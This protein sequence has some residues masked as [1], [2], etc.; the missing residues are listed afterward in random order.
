MIRNIKF[1]YNQS[2]STGSKDSKNILIKGDNKD[3][4]PELL[5]MYGGKIKC[6][7]IDP[8]YN[9]G[10]NYHYYN[11]NISHELWLREMKRTIMF[12]KQFL[13]R[14]GSLWISI[15][16]KEM[17]YLKVECDRIFGRE[18]FAGTIVWQHRKSREN[19]AVF[20]CNHEYILVY[21]CNVKA[22]KKSRNLI[23]VDEEFI[24][25]KY[26][27]PDNDP[28][29]PWQSITASAQAGHGV[30][31]QYYTVVSPTGVE[32]QPPLGRC[33]V[34]NEERMKREIANGN[35][36]FG[37][38]GNN[39]PRIKKFL[40][41]ANIGLTPET[42]WVNGDIG[43]TD[44][45]KKHLLTLFPNIKNVFDTPKPEGLIKQILEIATDT[46][47]YVLDCFL[48]SGTTIAVAH[49]LH[50]NYI[51]IEIG[52]QMTDMVVKRLEN[53]IQGEQGGI[54]NCVGWKGGGDF[55]YYDFD[56][57]KKET[58]MNEEAS[59][60]TNG[61]ETKIAVCHQL[62][63]LD[64]FDKYAYAPIVE[65]DVLKED[66]AAYATN[67]C[68]SD[69][70]EKK[71]LICLVKQDNLEQYINQ[72]AKL[73]YTGRKFPATVSLNE[74]YYFVPYLKGKGIRDLYLIKVVRVGN[75]KEGQIGENKNDF[76]LVFEIEFIRQLYEDYKPVELKIWRAFT[77]TTLRDV[78][79]VV[80]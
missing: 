62:N 66:L 26:K 4:L 52:E 22:F 36:W 75:R 24:N 21:A 74:L 55:A 49:K 60:S 45:A 44:S 78:M 33:W 59:I 12:L 80:V 2:L 51:G 39:A 35:I 5:P 20:S 1:I 13:R 40:A 37:I 56:K 18:N 72:S 46:D 61:Q 14:D 48:G 29:G 17:A 3:V 47:D 6:I 50:R 23:P 42:L 34:Y 68:V 7:Y 65:N 15:D 57:N 10:D 71:C 69:S 53:V 67:E 76:R 27:N 63:F 58:I 9:N 31:S 38:K 64:I 19:R 30:P 16:D 32:H 73:Y 43:T 25:S 77:D 28:R 41:G 70:V 79:N 8:P 54:S 11:D